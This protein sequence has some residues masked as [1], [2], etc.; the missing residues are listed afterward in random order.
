MT[1]T[2][3][4]A[5][6][7]IEHGRQWHG[8]EHFEPV[9]K[10]LEGHGYTNV[11]QAHPAVGSVVQDPY[12]DCTAARKTIESELAKGYAVLDS[13]VYWHEGLKRPCSND[14]IVVCHS[15]GGVVA[16]NASIGLG[17]KE[18]EARGEKNGIINIVFMCAFALPKGVSLWDALGRKPLP[19][20]V[21]DVSPRFLP[22]HNLDSLTSV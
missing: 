6:L 12:E 7:T 16:T 11:Y 14:V 10:L 13:T 17:K 20:F 21:M 22:Y 2:R 9:G 19:W 8:P 5:D 15:Y 4:D 18:R 3:A 1:D